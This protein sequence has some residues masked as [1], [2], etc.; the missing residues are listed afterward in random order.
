MSGQS[1]DER[2]ETSCECK[3]CN[4]GSGGGVCVYLWSFP[5]SH[6]AIS[7]ASF[8]AFDYEMMDPLEHEWIMSAVQSS[9]ETSQR[10]VETEPNL[11]NKRVRWR[12]TTLC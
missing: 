10:L 2:D 8:S 6:T 7:T 5:C 11:I 9:H 4:F 1:T 3:K 12:V